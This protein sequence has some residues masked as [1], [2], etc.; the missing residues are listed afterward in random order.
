[1]QDAPEFYAKDRQAWRSWLQKNHATKQAVWLIYDKGNAR[2]MSWGDIVQ[3]SLC[4]GWIDS[5]P[6]KV[7]DT[8]SKIYISKRKPSSGWSRVNKAHIEELVVR[9]LMMPAGQ[10]AIDAAKASGAWDKF[11][12][13]DNLQLS[14]ELI[15]AFNAN[16][17]AKKNFDSFT[18]SGRRII[19]EWLYQAKRPETAQTRIQK[20]I[21][22]AE[23][24]KKA[25]G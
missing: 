12:M 8:Q 23:A 11:S 20:I 21:E 10:Q 1:M 6:G 13:S 9:G 22:D 15:E 25:F 14:P 4:F 3:E 7:S 16:P 17:V 18:E 2:T 5:R 24:G 19:L